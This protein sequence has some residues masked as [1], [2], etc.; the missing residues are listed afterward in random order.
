M[1]LLTKV[2]VAV[3]ALVVIAGIGFYVY[4]FF[5]ARSAAPTELEAEQNVTR[6]LMLHNPNADVR[7]INVTPSALK[8]GSWDIV[9]S[10]VYNATRPCPILFIESFDYPLSL[11]PTPINNYT[12]FR[13]TTSKGCLIHGSP[14]EPSYVTDYVISSPYAAIAESYSSGIAPVVNYVMDYGYSSTNVTANISD[15]VW[16]IRYKAPAANYSQFVELSPSS[17]LII[18]NYTR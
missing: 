6:D 2:A 18:G 7:I 9:V 13:N 3:V 11:S 12:E 4:S 10:V 8:S 5:S 16:L 17:G 15:N 14:S 1:D